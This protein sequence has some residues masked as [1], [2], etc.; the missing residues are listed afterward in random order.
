MEALVVIG[1]AICR[2]KPLKSLV[3]SAVFINLITQP[4][5]TLGL[6]VFYRFYPQALLIGEAMIW[7]GEAFFLARIPANRLDWRQA[8]VLSLM[9][10]SLSF[11]VGLALPW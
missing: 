8:C 1:F 9:M 3:L 10:N 5:L 11:G 6:G 7:L 4:L 2:R